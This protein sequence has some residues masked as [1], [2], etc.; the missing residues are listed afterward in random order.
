MT[1]M[2]M[3]RSMKGAVIHGEGALAVP[4]AAFMMSGNAKSI[5][6]AD[7]NVL[8]AYF[9]SRWLLCCGNKYISDHNTRSNGQPLARSFV[10]DV[11][12]VLS[13]KSADVRPESSTFALSCPA[14][15]R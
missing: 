13:S 1:A 11:M 7:R 5:N 8:N 14:T 9:I 4:S 2:E 10:S 12:A 15:G 3:R 6:N